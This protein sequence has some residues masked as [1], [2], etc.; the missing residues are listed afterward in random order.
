MYIVDFTEDHIEQ[1]LTLVIE[2][3][4]EERR[5]L[6]V[7]PP[8]T[9]FP[10]LNHFAG[11]KLGVTAFEDSKMLG[12]LCCYKPFEDSFRTTGIKGIFSP[13]HVHAVIR[14]NRER[15]YKRLYQAAA[16]KWVKDGIR[17]HAIALYA[18]DR[19]ATNSFFVN[20]FGLRVIDA[21]RP[22]EKV[23]CM[24]APGYSF[25]ELESPRK[26]ETLGLK[27]LLI[28]H[29]SD[30]PMFMRRPF[31]DDSDL[32]KEYER[33]KPRYFVALHENRIVAWL[34]ITA[35]GEDF[36]GDENSVQNICGAFCIPE[37]RGKDVFQN[38]LNCCMEKFNNEGYS[39]LGVDFESFNPT[40]YGFWLKYF[41]PYIH[42]VVRRVDDKIFTGS[43]E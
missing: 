18:H 36:V 31:M 10:S 27:N 6:P 38:L 21:I 3:Y 20:G 17:S 40:A 30:S 13:V 26:V 1:A 37:H 22:V 19:Q 33:R 2:N 35:S 8:V 11:N 42:S 23:Q 41:T 14:E 43:K 9:A 5:Q 28:T 39:H 12:F 34:E 16:E 25:L 32:E 4:E 24:S 29:L 15:I 7:L